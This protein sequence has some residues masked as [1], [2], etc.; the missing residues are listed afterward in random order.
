MTTAGTAVNLP[1][2]RALVTDLLPPDVTATARRWPRARLDR[3]I[4]DELPL[5]LAPAHALGAVA[6]LYGPFRADLWLRHRTWAITEHEPG[7][8]EHLADAVAV[9]RSHRWALGIE[10]FD[11][12]NIDGGTGIWAPELYVAGSTPARI[13]AAAR[14]VLDG[15]QLA[16]SPTSQTPHYIWYWSRATTPAS[17]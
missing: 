9:L 7:N 14:R 17:S 8:L 6:A 13:I 16:H 5:G 4:G 11:R 12:E 15:W 2:L 3:F 10:L 1:A